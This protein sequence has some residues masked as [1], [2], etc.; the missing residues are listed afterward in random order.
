MAGEGAVEV[1]L[2]VEQM[3]L[4][5]GWA[6]LTSFCAGLVAMRLLARWN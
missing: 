5:L 6:V 3:A 1:Y 2:S 4:F